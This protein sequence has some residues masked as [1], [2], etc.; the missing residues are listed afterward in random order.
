MA[1]PEG[2]AFEIAKGRYSDHPNFD[3]FLKAHAGDPL[4]VNRVSRGKDMVDEPAL[5]AALA[6]QPDV[7]CGL[8]EDATMRRRGFLARW[9][10][11]LPRGM[12]G[13][14]QVG[15]KAVSATITDSYDKAMGALFKLAA[16]KVVVLSFARAAQDALSQ[17]ERWLEPQLGPGERL[18]YLAGWANKLAGAIARLAGIL[19]MAA[20]LPC[21]LPW[22]VPI[23]EDVVG[24]AI[25]LGKEYLLP[26][27]LAAF[28]LMGADKELEGAKRVLQWVQRE[29]RTEFKRYEAFGDLK[30]RAQLPRREDLDGP[31]RM[32]VD[33][34]I[35]RVKDS[36]GPRKGRPPD[37]LYETNPK[38]LVLPKNPKNP[39]NSASGA[40]S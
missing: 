23:H 5:S 3:V 40:I 16:K 37:R 36:A 33:H 20:T 4:R 39:K 10:Y 14:R 13:R 30:N 28:G 2:T 11:A 18:S 27:A 24:A 26:H 9:L 32:L 15:T 38:V 35:I 34:Q 1:G 31:L 29:G 25:Q 12:V 19:H 6:V 8:A 17:F 22:Q 7:I 21:D